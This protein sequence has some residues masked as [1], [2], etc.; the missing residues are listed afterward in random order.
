MSEYQYCESQAIDKP[1]GER[2]WDELRAISTRAHITATGFTNT[3]NWGNLRSHPEHLL[4]RDFD[5]FVCVVA[6]WGTHRLTLRL[7][8]YLVDVEVLSQ[9]RRS[10]VCAETSPT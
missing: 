10:R 5:T 9:Y 2:E 6:N 1:Q 8:R 3:Y 7:P 4:R